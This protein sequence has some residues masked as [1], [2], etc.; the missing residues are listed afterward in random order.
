MIVTA[1][2]GLNGLNSFKDHQIYIWQTA[3]KLV[4]QYGDL[5]LHDSSPLLKHTGDVRLTDSLSA[6]NSGFVG[7]YAKMHC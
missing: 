4:H 6:V 5:Y 2:L 1:R 3:S 7:N